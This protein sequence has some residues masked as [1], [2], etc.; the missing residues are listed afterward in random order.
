MPHLNR[1]VN[2]PLIASNGYK[3]YPFI[4]PVNREIDL[5]KTFDL[6]KL[7]FTLDDF[8]KLSKGTYNAGEFHLTDSGKLD[9]VNNHKT[10]TVFNNV[11]V[12]GADSF[13]IRVAFAKAMAAGGLDQN[14]MK[15]V[16][17]AL[18]LGPGYTLHGG[19]AFKPL[20][21]QEVRELIDKNIG[22]LNA[23]REANNQLKTY[24]QLHAGYSTQEKKDIAAA[25]AEI[26]RT[27]SAP[28]VPLNNELSDLMEVTKMNPSFKGLSVEDAEDY[29]EF[30]DE[31]ST[32][33]ECLQDQDAR[34]DWERENHTEYKVSVN[35]GPTDMAI[36]L[37]CGHVV[38]E[39]IT[40]GKRSRI[41][42][43][44]TPEKLKERHEQAQKLLNEIATLDVDDNIKIGKDDAEDGNFFEE[45]LE[46]SRLKKSNPSGNILNDSG[47]QDDNLEIREAPSPESRKL[48]ARKNL[49]LL[50]TLIAK[51]YDFEQNFATEILE[52][53][54]GWEDLLAD[55]GPAGNPT[56]LA[57]LNADLRD[58]LLDNRATIEPLIQEARADNA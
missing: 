21:R 28:K 17:K 49:N 15:G 55:C 39:T 6:N 27:G 36:A 19:E 16:R 29:L 22:T 23:R 7:H 54:E 8:Q 14:A 4:V 42:L 40:D 11:P 26:N 34:Y 1:A 10:W 2:D 44:Y 43:G 24:D 31:L 12:D 47:I 30:I 5:E 13:A 53:I 38:F 45:V 56:Q 35:G 50:A 57:D 46:K 52:Q 25:R 51:Q 33:L 37:K 48:T 9:I 20:T 41:A 32:A 18:G 3:A 58:F